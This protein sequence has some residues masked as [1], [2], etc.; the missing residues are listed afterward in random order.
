MYIIYT[1]SLH[2]KAYPSTW[3]SSLALPLSY[4]QWPP[5]YNSFTLSGPTSPLFQ[6]AIISQL[7]YFNSF[8]TGLYVLYLAPLE[9]ILFTVSK[10]IFKGMLGPSGCSKFPCLVYGAIWIQ[11]LPTLLPAPSFLPAPCHMWHS[12]CTDLFV[13]SLTCSAVPFLRIF[14]WLLPLSEMLSHFARLIPTHPCSVSIDFPWLL[15]ALSVPMSLDP[16]PRLCPSGAISPTFSHSI[17]C[18]F[19]PPFSREWAP[20]RPQKQ[21]SNNRV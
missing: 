14:A 3:A 8:L 16:V 7:D 11:P 12:H 20:Q 6:A 9:H 21:D 5:N 18:S 13:I 15:E 19:A 17:Y 2:S 10:G 1:C 4:H